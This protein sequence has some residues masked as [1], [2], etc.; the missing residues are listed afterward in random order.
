MRIIGIDPSLTATGIATID[1]T[2]GHIHTHTIST[3]PTPKDIKN[4]IHRFEKITTAIHDIIRDGDPPDHIRIHTETIHSTKTGNT[5]THRLTRFGTVADTLLDTM[6]TNLDLAIIEGPAYA[7]HGAGTWDRAGL[8][9]HIANHAALGINI[10][11]I[12]PATRCRYATGKGNAAKDVVMISA[13]RRYP[14]A[15]ITNN[16]EADAVIL[17]AIGAR[18]AGHPIDDPLPMANQTALTKLPRLTDAA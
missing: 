15:D 13:V 16:N 7:A 8:W 12:P 14:A 9:W 4:R 18:L 11:E 17:A 10:I 2:T 3:T 5:I 6:P 1:T